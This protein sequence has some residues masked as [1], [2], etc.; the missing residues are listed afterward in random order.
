MVA[1]AQT[2]GPLWVGE[3]GGRGR[4]C[5]WGGEDSRRPWGAQGRSTVAEV[6]LQGEPRVAPRVD[7]CPLGAHCAY[8]WGALPPGQGGVDSP[9]LPCDPNFPSKRGPRYLPSRV[10]PSPFP[11]VPQS[12]SRDRIALSL[13]HECPQQASSPSS[14]SSASLVKTGPTTPQNLP[15]WETP[16]P[17]L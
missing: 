8:N 2:P 7:Q 15:V 3:E 10:C 4:G 17:R 13:P 1:F 6:P 12:L 11:H 9:I 5:G 16:L 14:L